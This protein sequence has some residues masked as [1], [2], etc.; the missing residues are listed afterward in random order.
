GDEGGGTLLGTPGLRAALRA[1]EGRGPATELADAARA[2]FG[3]P[4]TWPARFTDAAELAS[5][6]PDVLSAQGDAVATAIVTAAAASLAATARAVGDGPVAMVGGLAGIEALRERIDL[7][8]AVGDVLDGTLRL[9]P[10]HEPH[11]VRVY[12]TAAPNGL[13]QLATEAV[14]SDLDDLDTRPIAEVVALLVAAEGEAHAAVVAALPRI[15]AGAEGIA[16]RLERGGRLIYA[17][18]GTPGRLG[19]LDAAECGP[20]FSTDIV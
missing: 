15:S 12:A 6:A 11:V 3:R 2:R 19:V 4:E 16:V 10:I 9:G 17:G 18:A 7:I 13:D 20:T 14:R 1:L 5:F 8:P